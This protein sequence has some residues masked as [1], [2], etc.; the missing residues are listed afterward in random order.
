MKK[1]GV[2]ITLV[3]AAILIIAG[4]IYF[5][6]HNQNKKDASVINIEQDA[7]DYITAHISELSPEKEVLGG[8]F[9]VTSI[10]SNETAD[11]SVVYGDVSYED[12]HNAYSAYY[13]FTINP[14]HSLS[15]KSFEITK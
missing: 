15:L 1:R 6:Q 7:K 11:G 9:Y 2:I 4:G 10:T 3:V 8:K 5:G 14:D 12:G 13:T